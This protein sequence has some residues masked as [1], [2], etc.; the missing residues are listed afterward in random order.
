MNNWGR[1]SRGCEKIDLIKKIPDIVG[2]AMS[3]YGRMMLRLCRK[4]CCASHKRCCLRQMMLPFGQ[5]KEDF[6]AALRHPRTSLFLR[7]SSLRCFPRCHPRVEPQS[8]ATKDLEENIFTQEWQRR[9]R[10]C[11]GSRAA[12]EKIDLIKKI[13]DIVGVDV[14]DDPLLTVKKNLNSITKT[15]G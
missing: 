8:G 13:P 10:Q 12:C 5:V 6:L 4:W 1:F 3:S 9:K 15:N 14:H 11:K 2:E 7:D